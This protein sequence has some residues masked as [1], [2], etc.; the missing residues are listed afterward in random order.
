MAKN[1][2]HPKALLGTASILLIPAFA[3]ANEARLDVSASPEDSGV[4]ELVVEQS[5]GFE[6]YI[7]GADAADVALSP[8]L[9]RDGTVGEI[10]GSWSVVRIRQLNGSNALAIQVQGRPDST[11]ASLDLSYDGDGNRHVLRVGRAEAYV[12]GESNAQRFRDAFIFGSVTGSGNDVRDNLSGGG[13]DGPLPQDSAIL[14]YRLNIVGDDNTVENQYGEFGSAL[15][16]D[17]DVEGDGN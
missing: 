5:P 10:E 17:V 11:A 16:Y 9:G 3:V 6:S 8:E 2:Y 12:S 15:N 13:S 7:G 4:N 1:F 14:E